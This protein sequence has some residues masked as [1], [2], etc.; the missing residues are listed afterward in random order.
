MKKLIKNIRSAKRPSPNHKLFYF[1]IAIMALALIWIINKDIGIPF[2]FIIIGSVFAGGFLLLKGINSPEVP[3]YVLVG[4]LP[5]N[6][7]LAGTFGGFMTALNLTNI[8][9][10]M[11]LFCWVANRMF[12]RKTIF[13]NNG[14]NWLILFLCI[15]GIFSVVRGGFY[16]GSRYFAEFIFPLK[17][18]LTP[19]LLYFLAMNIVRNREIFKN[20]V[21]IIMIVVAVAGLLA[22]KEGFDVGDASGS[23]DSSRVGGLAEQPNMMGAFFVYYMFLYLGFFYLYWQNFRYWGLLLPLLICF[24]GIQYTYSRGAF[25]GFALGLVGI[26]FFKNKWLFLLLCFAAFMAVLNPQVLPGGLRYAVDR[27]SS[28]KADSFYEGL[29]LEQTVDPSAG[30]RIEVWK[31]ALGIIKDNP[32]WGVGYGVFPYAI[33]YY[34]NL[35]E[36]DAH[37]TYFLIAAEM[38]I[39]VLLLFLLIILVVFKNTFWLYRRVKDKFFKS[40][41]LGMLGG[42]SGMLAV[43]MFGSRMESEEVSSYFW[44]LSG[45]II[46]AVRMYKKKQ[47]E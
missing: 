16:Y 17:R 14:L 6:K 13:Q 1:F 25:L 36:I 19:I 45:L 23:L 28:G 27:T 5:F 11:T 26:T 32:W 4:Y 9:F 15:F 29:P 46:S 21:V 42:L 10:L 30:K 37:N 34:T 35:Q 31:G 38:G 40:T 3:F 12:V 47:I 43:N 7:A 44:I 22:V 39:P 2:W 18:W 20:T 41:A 8:L 33:P 24:R